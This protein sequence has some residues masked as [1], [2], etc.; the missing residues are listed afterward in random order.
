MIPQVSKA[1]VGLIAPKPSAV[2]ELVVIC[3]R[4]DSFFIENA[5]YGRAA[6]TR[7]IEVKYSYD[8]FGLFFDNHDLIGV[9]I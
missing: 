2:N 9:F 3:G 4:F 6:I 8:D 5:G 1:Y 7:K